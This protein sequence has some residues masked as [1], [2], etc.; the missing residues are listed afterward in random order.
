MEISWKYRFMYTDFGC[1]VRKS[2]PTPKFL[3]TAEAYLVCDISPNFQIS[4][5]YAFIGYPWSIIFIIHLFFSTT[6]LL[7]RRNPNTSHIWYWE[8]T[9]IRQKLVQHTTT[10]ILHFHAKWCHWNWHKRYYK[11]S[12]D[13]RANFPAHIFRTPFHRAV[14]HLEC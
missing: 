6:T 3:G 11:I 13:F 2:S 4:L 1:P 8:I 5:I 10:F 9:I 7:F 12:L 14:Q